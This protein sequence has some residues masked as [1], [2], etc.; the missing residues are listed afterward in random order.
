MTPDHQ[1]VHDSVMSQRTADALMAVFMFVIGVVM[2]ASNYQLGAGWAKDGPE[3]GYFPFRI[4]AII[5]VASVVVFVQALRSRAGAARSFVTR[6]R[7]KP[8]LLVL[9]PTLLYVF[10]IQFIGIYAA[11]AI[12]IAGFMRMMGKY[13]WV[14]TLVISIGVNVLLF[15]LFEVQF[16]VPLP[17]GPLE[18]YFG[19]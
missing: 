8:V 16:L 1:R 10:G 12:F 19:Y 11:S 9:L 2:M 17:K 13:G 5:C 14:K 18:A 3:S 15:W 6:E 4:G 7:L